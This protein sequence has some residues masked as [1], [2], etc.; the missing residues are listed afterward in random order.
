MNTLSLLQPIVRGLVRLVCPIPSQLY[1]EC[2][3]MLGHGVPYIDCSDFEL[4][5]WQD[6]TK[7]PY[8]AHKAVSS[9]QARTAFTICSY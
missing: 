8:A 2:Y 1:L 7:E 3:W 9:A 5:S 4:V 6:Y